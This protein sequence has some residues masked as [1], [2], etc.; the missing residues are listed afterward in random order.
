[1]KFGCVTH[2]GP[3]ILQTLIVGLEGVWDIFSEAECG[4]SY[5]AKEL[6]QRWW[7]DDLGIWHVKKPH[8]RQSL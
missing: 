1:M 2:I 4:S 5:S 6:A 8:T 3:W 7:S